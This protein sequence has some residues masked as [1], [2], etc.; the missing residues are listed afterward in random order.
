M[1]FSQHHVFPTDYSWFCCQKCWL[2]MHGFTSRFSILFHWSMN[3]FFLLVNPTVLNS[4]AFWYSLKSESVMSNTFL[5][6][7]LIGVL[8]ENCRWLKICYTF[9][10]FARADN[11]IFSWAALSLFNKLLISLCPKVSLVAQLVKDLPALRETWVWSLCWQDPLEKGK[12][13][14]SSILAWRIPWAV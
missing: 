5:K 2:N 3:L 1:Q 12:A 10:Q 7:N 11:L 14:H 6:L 13:T 9:C 8:Y 4:L